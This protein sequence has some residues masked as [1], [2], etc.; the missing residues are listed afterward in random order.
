MVPLQFFH[1]FCD[2]MD[3]A[4]TQRAPLSVFSALLNFFPKK[5]S[6]KGSPRQF[7]DVLQQ[8]MF[9]NLKESPLSSRKESALGHLGLSKVFRNSF[10][11]FD[12]LSFLTLS[13][14][15]AIFEP[16]I[17]RRLMPFPACFISRC[18][19]H[20]KEHDARLRNKLWV[21]TSHLNDLHFQSKV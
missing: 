3:V 18:V 2:R 1:M 20:F 16:Q 9:G 19:L 17:W 14:P 12:T 6:S 15:F 5:N 10:C 7:F 11:E 8:W 21:H 4:K 13:Y